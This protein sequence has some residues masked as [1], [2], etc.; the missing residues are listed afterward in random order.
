MTQQSAYGMR[1]S[2]G[3]YS[4]VGKIDM[5]RFHAP[6]WHVN[7]NLNSNLHVVLTWLHLALAIVCVVFSA[8]FVALA[9]GRECDGETCKQLA[10]ITTTFFS[11][12]HVGSSVGWPVATQRASIGEAVQ[13]PLDRDAFSFSH[14]YECMFDAQVGDSVCKDRSSVGD[15]TACLRNSTQATAALTACDTL[16]ASFSQPWPTA[17]EYLR[18]IYRFPVMRNTVSVRASQN[19]FRSCLSRSLWPFFEVQQSIDSPL[20]LGSY[21]W[22][23]MLAVGFLCMTS[24]AVYT[25]SPWEQVKVRFG[26]PDWHMRLGWMWVGISFVWILAFFITF[27]IVAARHGTEFEKNGGVPTTNSTSYVTLVTLGVCLFYFLGELLE[28]TQKQEYVVKKYNKAYTR[29]FRKEKTNKEVTDI[30]PHGHVVRQTVSNVKRDSMLGAIMPR[31]TVAVY[32]ISEEDVAKYYT[33]PLLAVWAD[34]YLADPL[35]FLGMAGATGH[36]R[37]DQAWNLFFGVLFFRLIN[38]QICRYMYQCFMNNLAFSG[39]SKVN[40]IYYDVRLFPKKP[41]VDYSARPEVPRAPE[42]DEQEGMESSLRKDFREHYTP[43]GEDESGDSPDGSPEDPLLRKSEKA[44]APP[45]VPRVAHLKIQVM[46]LSAQIAAIF[47]LSAI[48]FVVFSPDTPLSDVPTFVAF[49]I[50]GLIVPEALRTLT[51]IAC[52]I[53]HPAHNKVT[54]ELLNMHMFLWIWDLGVRLIF[55]AAVILNLASPEGSRRFLVEKSSE[56]LDVYLPLLSPP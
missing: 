54:W 20:F 31:P 23:I 30:Y 9:L 18:C 6:K 11:T 49:V 43:V 14:Y 53:W 48:C 40:D 13:Y 12:S 45:D 21:N 22:L 35:I 28:S 44:D 7:R 39:E 16:S 8:W 50:L 17:E 46:A 10:Y 2:S 41:N 32:D 1:P 52:Q 38:M 42:G 27:V 19:V 33:P 29:F 24:F 4:R 37:T 34:G 25:A 15:Y 47:L 3:A 5:T 36:L 26:E 56:L 51:H 55:L